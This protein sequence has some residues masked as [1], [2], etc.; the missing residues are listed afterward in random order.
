MSR[1]FVWED[2]G[3][4]VVFRRGGVED[5]VALL[6]ERGFERFELLS[7]PRAL[8]GAG[9]LAA[10]AASAVHEVGPG[11]VADLAAPLL[12]QVDAATIVALGG[13]RVIDVAKSVASVH[14]LMEACAAINPALAG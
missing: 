10:A 13:G 7:T 3:R 8:A 12:D 4:T 9:E 2:A 6:R 11:A 14:A 5:A 1:D